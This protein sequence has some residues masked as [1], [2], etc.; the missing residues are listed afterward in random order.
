MIMIIRCVANSVSDELAIQLGLGNFSPKY[1]SSLSPGTEYVVLG[2][3]YLPK[4]EAYGI[5]PTILVKNDAG[6]H[7]FAPIAL[8]EI[9]EGTPSIYW[10]I[11]WSADGILK[12][13]PLSFYNDFYHDDLVEGVENVKRDFKT[14]VKKLTREARKKAVK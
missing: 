7:S 4:S 12:M 9:I 3:S 6:G 5:S 1:F 8:F 2:I 13:W 10:E 11:R 14:V